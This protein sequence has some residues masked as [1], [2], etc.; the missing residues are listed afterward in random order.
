VSGSDQAPPSFRILSLDGGGIRGVFPAALL[1]RLEEHLEHPVGRYFDLIAGTSTGGIIAIGLGL[2]L[3]A[4]DILRLYED[5]GPAIFDQQHGPVH[6][7]LRGQWRSGRHW[8]G[9]KY[10]A[11]QLREALSAVLGERR[12]GES[13]TRLLIPAWHPVLERVYIYKTAHHPR[14]ETDYMQSAVDAALATVAAPTFLPAHRTSDGVELV[15]G[16]I[17]A[18]NPIGAAVIEAVGLLEW[19]AAQ[20][21]ILS[22]GTIAEPAAP[23]RWRG[24]LP[25]SAHVMRLFMAGQSHSA[26]GTAKIITGDGHDHRA[27]WRIDQLAPAGRYTLDN[28]SRIAEMKS[29]AVA[30]AREQLPELR[31][32]FFDVPARP[33][34]PYHKL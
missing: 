32:H 11:D 21:K 6:N 30:E 25:M 24:K 20:L 3:P 2:G 33:F 28:A 16:G 14:L 5:Q 10:E 31:R 1:A 22:I 29:R 19:P 7:W 23:P 18:N 12:L 9:S 15:D 26:L 8:F 13:Q 27:I 4:K 34:D 17:W